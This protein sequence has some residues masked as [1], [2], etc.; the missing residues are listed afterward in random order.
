MGP[1][2]LFDKSFLQSLSLDESVW[3]DN[4]FISNVC[5]IFFAETLA[6][7]SKKMKVDRSP[8]DEVRII[9]A[10]FPESSGHPNVHH[11]SACL[12]ELLG[13]KIPMIGQIQVAGGQ[14]MTTSQGPTVVFQKSDEAKA[15][16]RWSRLEFDELERE[17]A[18]QWR[19]TLPILD[20]GASAAF[21]SRIG[22][23]VSSCKT[24]QYAKKLADDLVAGK[25][26]FSDPFAFVFSFLNLPQEYH[27]RI[28][29]LWQS[30]GFQNMFDYAPYTA[31]L[32]SLW[33]FFH[34]ALATRLV[35][36]RCSNSTD[37][38]YLF[39]LPFCRVFV[40]SDKLHRQVAP[41]FLRDDQM[42]VWGLDLKSDLKKLN[43]HYKNLPR[44]TRERGVICFAPEPP[45]D[46]DFLVTS[47]WDRMCP[48][49]RRP[50]EKST[51]SESREFVD[52]AE[53][54]RQK[55]K[56][57][58][59]PVSEVTS[60]LPNVQ[61]VSVQRRIQRKKGSWFQVPKDLKDSDE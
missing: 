1:T 18:Q 15:F 21:L 39:Y 7:L 55:T 9:A 37:V 32:L 53:E 19:T 57:S 51:S 20:G 12:S 31:H 40:S 56:T 2:T 29:T 41:L 16:S 24:L 42:F 3:F 5:P 28:I 34:I 60:E 50:G 43:A 61:T 59:V 26:T 13:S 54:I 23:D 10:K 49:W 52:L 8:E 17:Y 47:I 46:G 4:F 45:K 6:D 35:S 58:S 27:N 33:F 44:E 36:T 22:V 48:Y 11:Q 25:L 14:F 30:A 38:A